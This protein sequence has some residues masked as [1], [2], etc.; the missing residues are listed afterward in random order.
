MKFKIVITILLIATIIT[1]V[2]IKMIP[3]EELA[4]TRQYPS[5]TSQ[6]EQSFYY[7]NSSIIDYVVAQVDKISSLLLLGVWG[8][9]I[10][11]G[12]KKLIKFKFKPKQ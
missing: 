10:F 7:T 11:M 3:R 5:E 9:N 4:Y 12:F 6:G 8:K 1:S 2:S